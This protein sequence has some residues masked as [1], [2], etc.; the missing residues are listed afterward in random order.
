M[1]VLGYLHD[2]GPGDP[3]SA[4]GRTCKK[5]GVSVRLVEIRPHAHSRPRLEIEYRR[6]GDTSWTRS[7]PPCV[8]PAKEAAS[9]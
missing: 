2:L 3:N 4:E 8:P 1:K 9:A 5:C 6:P 7:R